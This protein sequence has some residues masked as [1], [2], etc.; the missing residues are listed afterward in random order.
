[1]YTLEIFR[2]SH[3]KKRAQLENSKRF[4][5]CPINTNPTYHPPLNLNIEKHFFHH[6]NSVKGF[7]NRF[8]VKTCQH[9]PECPGCPQF[10]SN[11]VTW[12]R[13]TNEYLSKECLAYEDIP[14]VEKYIGAPKRESYRHRC[15]WRV[16]DSKDPLGFFYGGTQT[17][18]PINKC[19][20][21]VP[22]I[23]LLSE[24]LRHFLRK[25]TNACKVLSTIDIRFDRKDLFLTFCTIEKNKRNVEKIARQFSHCENIS[26]N[27]APKHPNAIMSG[28][29]I[30][31]SGK[32]KLSWQLGENKYEA[33][34]QSFFQVNPSVLESIHNSIRTHIKS[35]NFDTI[36]DFYSGIGVHSIQLGKEKSIIGFDGSASAIIDANKNATQI[37]SHKNFEFIHANDLTSSLPSPPPNTLGIINPSR[38]GVSGAVVNHLAHAN[39]NGLIYISCNAKTL[40]RDLEMLHILGFSTDKIEAYEMMPR[41]DHVELVAFLSRPSTPD[42]SEN[43]AFWPEARSMELGVSGPKNFQKSERSLWIAIVRGEVPHGTPPGGKS[44]RVK[45]IRKRGKMAVVAIESKDVDEKDIIHVFKRWKFPIKGKANGKEFGRPLLHCIK[46]GEES[47]QVP[48]FFSAISELPAA[49]LAKDQFK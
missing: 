9:R 2:K 29:Q 5:R 20:I 46:S 37:L 41:T 19:E 26:I 31:V 4:Y 45:R 24:K 49:L 40:F 35:L 39:F 22:E 25:N 44:I 30:V 42:Y 27:F 14:K 28:T 16:G 38:S 36:Y 18:L 10:D 8:N 43:F 21:H 34:S 17:F 33:S 3:C 47:A 7:F 23:E 11:F 6:E 13:I 48:G 15:R 12:K 32:E 1:M